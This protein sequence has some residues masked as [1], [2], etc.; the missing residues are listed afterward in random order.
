VVAGG[1]WAGGVAAWQAGGPEALRD[2]GVEA[3]WV[4]EWRHSCSAGWRPGVPA[5][6]MPSG[7]QRHG[8]LLVLSI[9][10]GVAK[11]SMG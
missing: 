2:S 6:Q 9:Y 4:S 1:W 5:W 7:Q 3:W 11:P 10:C 8:S